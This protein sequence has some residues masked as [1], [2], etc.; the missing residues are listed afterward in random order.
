MRPRSWGS[1]TSRQ[2]STRFPSSPW[3]QAEES[4]RAPLHA[5][6]RRDGEG[7]S[8]HQPICLGVS[9]RETLTDE[10]KG[11]FGCSAVQARG[12]VHSERVRI[13]LSGR[14]TE[15]SAPS[16]RTS[17]RRRT[18]FSSVSTA[19]E[20]LLRAWTRARG[21][22]ETDQRPRGHSRSRITSS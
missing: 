3:R 5:P 11:A 21:S 10:D 14:R 13:R 19:D 8:L 12:A 7:K 20:V 17:A 4:A 2:S 15:P 22:R 16:G 18:C 1:R 9:P 6:R